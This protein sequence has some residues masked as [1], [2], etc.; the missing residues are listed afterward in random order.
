MRSDSG[1]AIAFGGSPERQ[2]R[3]VRHG[4]H[5]ASPSPG[6]VGEVTAGAAYRAMVQPS[7]RRVPSV[8]VSGWL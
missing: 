8:R 5:A 3:A 6:S 2:G 4:R 1:T 7:Q